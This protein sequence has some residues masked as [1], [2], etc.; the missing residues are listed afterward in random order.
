MSDGQLHGDGHARFGHHLG[1]TI[2]VY[3]LPPASALT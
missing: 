2:S 1:S 3:G